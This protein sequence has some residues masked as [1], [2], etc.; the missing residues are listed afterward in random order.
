M[1]FFYDKPLSIEEVFSKFDTDHSGTIDKKEAK[2]AK[3]IEIFKNFK[4]KKGMTLDV[5]EKKN[6]NSYAKYEQEATEAYKKQREK[7]NNWLKIT[8]QALEE[9]QERE[10]ELLEKMEN[11]SDEIEDE[12]KNKNTQSNP[13]IYTNDDDDLFIIRRTPSN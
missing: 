8:Q 10:L 9:E 4:V 6:L 1:G 5:F 7:V 13:P 11:E 3:S 2:D 12:P